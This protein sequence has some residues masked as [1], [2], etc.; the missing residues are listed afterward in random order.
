M[1]KFSRIFTAVL[2]VVIV[3]IA[4]AIPSLVAYFQG[5]I[6]Y[7]DNS[8]GNLAEVSLGI[9]SKIYGVL[10]IA[11]LP[12]K[13]IMHASLKKS[14]SVL[15]F[16]I[17]VPCLYVLYFDEDPIAAI[18][19]VYLIE[20]AGLA[21]FMNLALFDARKDVSKNYQMAF[22]SIA[23]PAL[24][25][26]FTLGFIGT[27]KLEFLQAIYNTPSKGISLGFMVAFALVSSYFMFR[28]N[29]FEDPK[30]LANPSTSEMPLEGEDMEAFLKRRDEN[31]KTEGEE[32]LNVEMILSFSL[33]T[34][35]I[36]V[37][38]AQELYVV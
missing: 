22:T 34:L 16:F 17:L 18:Y 33:I 9:L 28:K 3:S 7:D 27:I 29:G 21:L 15:A 10:L 32:K 8:F 1:K 38:L 37:Y 19:N 30:R 24:L 6:V 20:A 14:L 5:A 11:M 36:I 2:N 12:F 25:A 26:V 23:I 31:S 35:G 13:L 4:V